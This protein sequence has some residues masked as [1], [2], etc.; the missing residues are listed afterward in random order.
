MKI[1]YIGGVRHGKKIS[2]LEGY[3]KSKLDWE[4]KVDPPFKQPTSQT[5]VTTF[6]TTTEQET[7]QLK[8]L[9][10]N[11]ELKYFYVVQDLSREEIESS[12]DE[13]WE[14][15]DNLGYDFD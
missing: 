11:G 10:K 9:K 3:D 8:V 5:N 7:Y 14:N 6:T 1:G 2:V 4:I 13:C 15:S 12:L